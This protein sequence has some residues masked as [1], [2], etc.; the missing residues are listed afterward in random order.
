MTATLSFPDATAATTA[1]D[2]ARVR[3]QA[4]PLEGLNPADIQYF[5]DDTAPLV[6]ER[7]RREDPVHRSFSP[8]PGMGHYWSVTR[9]QDIMAVDTQHA[10]FSSDWR[11]GGITLMDFPPGE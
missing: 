2:A 11:K 9:H 3:I 4:L 1:A 6:F 7:L 10:A 5:V 8:V